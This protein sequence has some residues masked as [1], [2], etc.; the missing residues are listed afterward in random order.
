M[1]DP[2]QALRNAKDELEEQLRRVDAALGIL[3]PTDSTTDGRAPK[4]RKGGGRRT[5]AD[6]LADLVAS[7]PSE[8]ISANEAAVAL[9]TKPANVYGPAA[10]LEKERRIRRDGGRYY[11]V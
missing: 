6:Q 1:T 11:P 7:K 2:V 8:G 9:K 4:T 5:R 10:Q 3:A